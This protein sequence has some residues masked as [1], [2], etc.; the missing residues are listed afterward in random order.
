MQTVRNNWNVW[1]Y[2]LEATC[3]T[4]IEEK[5]AACNVLE[6][7]GVVTEWALPVSEAE[8]TFLVQQ[9]RERYTLKRFLHAS[10]SS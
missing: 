3:N 6:A 7:R 10:I 8:K 1:Q 4:D 2:L 5:L 9:L